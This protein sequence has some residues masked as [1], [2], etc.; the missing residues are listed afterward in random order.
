MSA[1]LHESATCF[2]C[3]LVVLVS[4]GGVLRTCSRSMNIEIQVHMHEMH[5]ITEDY[6]KPVV[7]KLCHVKL[8]PEKC[9]TMEWEIGA[10]GDEY[11]PRASHLLTEA[12]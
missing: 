7:N 3:P 11:K 8:L 10:D 4:L 12:H 5:D 9:I 2:K 6:M 1:F